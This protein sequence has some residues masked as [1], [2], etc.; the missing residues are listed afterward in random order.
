VSIRQVLPLS[1]VS[2]IALAGCAS[3]DTEGLERQIEQ[4]IANQAAGYK[5]EV[6]CP[7]DVDAGEGNNFDCTVVGEN[8]NKATIRVI[9]EDG[10]GDV[11]WEISEDIDE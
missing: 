8:G 4:S 5:V 6:S 11:R 1:I 10:E 7:E 3:L 2:L 9:Q